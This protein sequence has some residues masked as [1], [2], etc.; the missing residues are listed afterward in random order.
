LLDTLV[1]RNAFATFANGFVCTRVVRDASDVFS[2]AESCYA[3]RTGVFV[4]IDVIG[5]L[6][7][8]FVVFIEGRAACVFS[9]TSCEIICI[10]DSDARG[11]LQSDM[12]APKLHRGAA[13][14]RLS[15]T[16]KRNHDVLVVQDTL[17]LG[18][19]QHHRNH[20]QYGPSPIITTV[21][22]IRT[23]MSNNDIHVSQCMRA[24]V[25]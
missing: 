17:T 9:Y 7:R 14:P 23:T 15:C 6:K 10:R 11:P 20:F 25:Q 18:D 21:V 4:Y 13:T 8:K 3:L 16:A 22:I 2:C 24:I 12:L 5:R 19:S 1:V